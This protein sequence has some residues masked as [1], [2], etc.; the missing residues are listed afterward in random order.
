MKGLFWSTSKEK[1][2]LFFHKGRGEDQGRNMKDEMGTIKYFFKKKC[3]EGGGNIMVDWFHR[4][5]G[6]HNG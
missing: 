6:G 5:M 1:I 3:I 4:G 2:I